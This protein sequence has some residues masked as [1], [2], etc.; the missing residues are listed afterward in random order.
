MLDI[1]AEFNC[2]EILK[3]VGKKNRINI[4]TKLDIYSVNLNSQRLF[5]FKK[6]TVCCCCGIEGIIIR[7]E[8][9]KNETPHFNLYAK[10]NNK[11]ILMTKDHIIPK[12][13]GG[14][15]NISNYQTMCIICNNIKSNN[16]IIDNAQIRKLNE[17]YYK[18]VESGK[19]HNVAFN[20]ISRKM[21]GILNDTRRDSTT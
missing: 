11:L 17:E 7:L 9:V 8:R 16:N 21:F 12:S 4:N 19:T 20:M 5:L 10:K 14:S 18:E 13:K 15:N 1:L 2:N 3:L 6:S